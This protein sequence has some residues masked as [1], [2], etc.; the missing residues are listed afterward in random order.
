[1]SQLVPK[2]RDGYDKP[3]GLGIKVFH[4]LWKSLWINSA[5]F[6]EKTKKYSHT[7]KFSGFSQ[8]VENSTEKTP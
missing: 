8:A 6:V 2:N 5:R 7:R 3:P 1:M 4:R